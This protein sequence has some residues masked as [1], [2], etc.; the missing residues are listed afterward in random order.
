MRRLFNLKYFFLFYLNP[1]YF[2]LIDPNISKVFRCYKSANR[3]NSMG[4]MEVTLKMS[5]CEQLNCSGNVIRDIKSDWLFAS[6]ELPNIGKTCKAAL[7]LLTEPLF[8]VV[9]L[10]LVNGKKS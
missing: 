6:L 10:H 1:R 4:A 2:T 8:I 5:E 7:D 3:A 9:C